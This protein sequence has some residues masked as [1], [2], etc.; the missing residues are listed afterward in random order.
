MTKGFDYAEFTDQLSFKI[1]CP[2]YS[3]DIRKL[4]YGIKHHKGNQFQSLELMYKI[5]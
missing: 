5:S 1:R 2:C 4:I 3:T